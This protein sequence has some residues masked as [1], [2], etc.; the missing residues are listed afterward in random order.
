[1]RVHTAHNQHQL[2]ARRK[3][4]LSYLFISHDLLVVRHMADRVAI[5]YLSKIVELA[6]TAEVFAGHRGT[7]CEIQQ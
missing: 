1:V 7:P 3:R 6:P 5:M 4:N 2:G